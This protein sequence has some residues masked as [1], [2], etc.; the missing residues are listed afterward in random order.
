MCEKEKRTRWLF[1]EMFAVCFT[2]N[3]FS[4]DEIKLLIFLSPF[5]FCIL[6]SKCV[7]T[8]PHLLHRA[9]LKTFPWLYEHS[10][11]PPCITPSFTPPSPRR[12]NQHTGPPGVALQWH[13]HRRALVRRPM[14]H[15][16]R[17]VS[18]NDRARRGMVSGKRI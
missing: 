18:P 5:Y 4:P 15:R 14:H 1:I 3:P 7:H 13:R 6:I 11:V 17:A 8:E 2:V 16:Q 9:L 10:F 12:L